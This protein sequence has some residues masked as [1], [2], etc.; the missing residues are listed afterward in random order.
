MVISNIS[1]SRL[2]AFLT[3]G[4]LIMPGYTAFAGSKG[5]GLPDKTAV[6]SQPQEGRIV[7]GTITDAIDGTPLPGVNILIRNT[8]MGTITNSEG[9]YT[10]MIPAT[11]KDPVLVF[12]FVGYMSEEIVVGDQENITINL[13]QDIQRLSEVVV[14]GYGESSRKLLT[15]A[16]ATVQEEQLNSSISGGIEAALQGKTSGIQVV[17]NSGTPGAS[18]S[19]NIRGKSSISAGNQPLYVIDGIPVITGDYGQISFEGQN[20][21]AS[22][23]L[24]PNNIESISILK[25]ASSAAIYGAR[26]ANGV[27]LITTKKGIRDRTSF[28]FNA[29]TGWQKEW[30]RLDMMGAHEWKEYVSTFDSAFVDAL[31]PNLDT[32]DWQDEVFR[33]APVSN[34]E[35]S[36]KGGN[37]KIRYYVSGRYFDQNGIVLGSDYNKFSTRLNL[38]FDATEKL[39]FSFKSELISSLNNRIVGDQTINGVLPNAISKP[40]IYAVRDDLGNYLEEGFWDNP[41]AIG[42]EVTN[43]ARVVRNISSFDWEYDILPDLSF[44]NQWGVDIY[45]LDERRYEPTTVKRGAQSN[46][47]GISAKS[48]VVKITQQSILSWK[49][50]LMEN[51]DI[52]LMAGYSFEKTSERYNWIRGIDFPSDELEYLISSGDI[53]EASSNGEDAG[54]QSFF[55]RFMYNYS[56]KYLFNFNFRRDGS[57]NFGENNRYANFPGFSAAWRISEESFMQQVKFIDELKLKASYGL[58]GNDRITP[59]ASRS[60]YSSGYNYNGGPGTS[61]K[62]IPNPDLRWETTSSMNLGLEVAFFSNRIIFSTDAYLN[63]TTD[64]LLNKPIPG[65]SGFSTVSANVG[66]LENRGLEFL[67]NT[68]NL[69]GKIRWTTDINFSLNRNE[70]LEL[71][72]DQPI[73][74]IGRGGNAV[75]VGYPIGVFYMYRSLGVDPSTGDLLL[76]DVNRDGEITDADRTVVADPNPDFIGGFTNT[77]EYLGFDLSIFFQFSYGNDIFNGTRQYAESM[78]FGTSDNQLVTIKDRWKEPGD[79]TYV[80]RHDGINNL[81]PLSS[82]Y[83]EDGSYLRI[84]DLTLGYSLSENLI[85]KS[86]VLSAARIYVKFQNLF[87]LTPYSGFDPEMNY[88]GVVTQG[89]NT[90][91]QG[92]DFFTYPQPRIYSIGVSLNF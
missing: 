22:I 15:N 71:Y 53:E 61:P 51:H 4:V 33:V 6:H 14:I 32:T 65:S 10:L 34:I 38:D 25:D 62:Q 88:G 87:T 2:F 18:I 91:R 36:V 23:D 90:V 56:N 89:I 30:R 17:Q 50:T 74:D 77:L 20:L 60:L 92:T 82:H 72:K 80:P 35:L 49:K 73:T 57:S 76:D 63:K 45:N 44:K 43:E 67:I 70:V 3:L 64:L 31:D 28:S 11:E 40:P 69:E 85:R 83:I 78:K 7:T 12:S 66:S 42:N 58:A 86:V 75:L 55:G 52:N 84:K 59:F 68:V 46:G 24:N 26:A 39:R 41:V 5:T 48:D 19:V 81:F 1:I 13:V 37:Q 16:I 9:T 79:I 21:D 27:I 29:Y 54:L 47:I 8:T